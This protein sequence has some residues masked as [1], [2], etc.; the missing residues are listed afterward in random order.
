MFIQR[1]KYRSKVGKLR[2]NPGQ[3]ITDVC[4]ISSKNSDFKLKMWSTGIITEYRGT[5][6]RVADFQLRDF[7]I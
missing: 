7:G 5:M 6:V 4:R 2:N 1:N 3:I